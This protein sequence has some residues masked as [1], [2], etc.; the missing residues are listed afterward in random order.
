LGFGPAFSSR[1]PFERG[2]LGLRQA[3]RKSRFHGGSLGLVRRLA[4]R[5]SNCSAKT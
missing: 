5:N 2:A 3:N 1:L 4:R